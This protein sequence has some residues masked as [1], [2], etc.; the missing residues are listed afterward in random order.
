MVEVGHGLGSGEVWCRVTTLVIWYRF[1]RGVSAVGGKKMCESGVG[2]VW[3]VCVGY[4]GGCIGWQDIF[5]Q[6]QG[7]VYSE[8]RKNFTW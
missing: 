5:D 2:G 6:E 1:A 3:V 8:N 7:Y 4:D